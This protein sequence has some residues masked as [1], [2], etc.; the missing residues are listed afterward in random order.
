MCVGTTR[1]N[2]P[3][4]TE[5]SQGRGPRQGDTLQRSPTAT[6]QFQGKD[7]P[8]LLMDEV[9][10]LFPVSPPLTTEIH[11]RRQYLSP[12]ETP[13]PKSQ[14]CAAFRVVCQSNQHRCHPKWQIP[15]AQFIA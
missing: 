7:P 13:H 8:P 5:E 12:R 10:S 4:P 11:S 6:N 3:D 14:C 1:G 15:P 9:V 2:R